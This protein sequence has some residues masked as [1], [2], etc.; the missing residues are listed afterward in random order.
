[1]RIQEVLSKR[2]ALVA[3]AGGFLAMVP[4]HVWANALPIGSLVPPDTGELDI[5]NISGTLVGVTSI[6]PCINWSGGT[7]CSTPLATTNFTVGGNS[8]LFSNTPS[9]T[10]QIKNVGTPPPPTETDFETVLGGTAVGGATVHFDLVQIVINSGASAG[11]CNS[12]AAFTTCTPHNSPFTF[13]ENSLGNG[14][15]ISFTVL[16]NA[17]TVSSAGGVTPYSASFIT[18]G[19]QTFSGPGTPGSNACL[20]QA[21]SITEVQACEGNGGTITAGFTAVE[22]PLASSPEPIGFSLVGSGL[23][24]LGFL[25]R[26]RKRA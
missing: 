14:I 18:P 7:T 21:A 15:T 24:V 9:A 23:L 25:G 22:Q 13:T 26:R 10:D 5:S 19:I 11:N 4:A 6:P 8:A 12:N 17:Y 3:L 20:G 1:M 2:L 16:L